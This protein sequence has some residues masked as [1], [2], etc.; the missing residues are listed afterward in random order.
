MKGLGSVSVRE[1][2]NIG[3]WGPSLSAEDR[4]VEGLQVL[5]DAER[6]WPRQSPA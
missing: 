3:M 4:A 5:K 1:I 2:Y 6:Y